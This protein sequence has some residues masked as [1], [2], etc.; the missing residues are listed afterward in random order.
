MARGIK[1]KDLP[2]IVQAQVARQV[3]KPGKVPKRERPEN[4]V[5]RPRKVTVDAR[6]WFDPQRLAETVSGAA[7]A[8]PNDLAEYR[9]NAERSCLTDVV[10]PAL[11]LGK[12]R[13]W[14]YELVEL[15][16][17]RVSWT[18]DFLVVMPDGSLEVWEVKGHMWSQDSVRIRSVVSVFGSAFRFKV[19]YIDRRMWR[20]ETMEG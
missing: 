5:K 4:G 11:S 1:L 16:L 17:G 2:A 7:W 18:P 3:K 13:A 6:A 20:V 19:Y 9:S 10:M 12:I 8:R 14:A 15:E